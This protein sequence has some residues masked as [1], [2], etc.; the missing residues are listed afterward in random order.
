MEQRTEEIFALPCLRMDLKTRHTQGEEYPTKEDA[1]PVVDCSFVTGKCLELISRKFSVG[2]VI[3][4]ILIFVVADFDNHI[5]VTTDAEAFF[6]LHDLI[7]SYV[8]EKERVLSIQYG[9][10]SG[11]SGAPSKS[12]ATPKEK[13]DKDATQ[14][15]SSGPGGAAHLDPHQVRL[16]KYKQKIQ[17]HICIFTPLYVFLPE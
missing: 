5:Y 10:A 8:K 2:T 16:L 1:K 15:G 14:N 17:I 9:G 6:F 3:N 7:T 13:L 11:G 12:A 4:D